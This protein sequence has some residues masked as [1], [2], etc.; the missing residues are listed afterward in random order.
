MIGIERLHHARDEARDIIIMQ[1]GE[2]EFAV[3]EL[4]M[5]PHQTL[6]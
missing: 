5:N 2:E 3:E 6:A 1:K 4:G